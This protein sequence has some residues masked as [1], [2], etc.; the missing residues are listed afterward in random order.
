MPLRLAMSELWP[1]VEQSCIEKLPETSNVQDGQKCSIK[2]NIFVKELTC[3]L[4]LRVVR[5]RFLRGTTFAFTTFGYEKSNLQDRIAAWDFLAHC[6]TPL[7]STN[8]SR[9]Y[10]I[11]IAALGSEQRGK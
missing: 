4:P 5:K 3:R 9:L 11:V 8:I 10:N 1:K 7:D 2:L 6:G